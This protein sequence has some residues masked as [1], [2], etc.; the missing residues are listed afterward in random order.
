MPLRCPLKE[1]FFSNPNFSATCVA[2]ISPMA[3]AEER[4]GDSIP[5]ALKK[6][7]ASSASPITKSPPISWARS[8]AKDVMTW[9]RG[10]F[11]TDCALV[12]P[13][14]PSPSAVVLIPSLLSTSSAVGP[15]KRLPCTVGVTRTPLPIL[16]GNWKMVWLT[17]LPA[18]LSSSMY[19]PR[20]AMICNLCS[21]TILLNLSA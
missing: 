17:W 14:E 21:L 9:R 12:A 6:P 4:P 3:G 7:S 8:P 20:R 19:W 16:L 13:K 2:T 10:T 11:L 18:L 1:G 5:A 15:T